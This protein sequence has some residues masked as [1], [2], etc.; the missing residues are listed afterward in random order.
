MLA[1]VMRVIA[2][3]AKSLE[4]AKSRLAPV[5]TP[6]ERA[7]LSVVMLRGVLEACLDQP[8]WEVRVVS[9][10][11]PILD[12][13]ERG[14]A[15]PVLEDGHRLQ[16]AVRQAEAGLPPESEL[17]V[18]LADLP[19][20][21]SRALSAAL[22]LSDHAS[23]VAAPAASDGGTNLLLRHP[24]SAIPARFGRASFVRHRSEAYRRG[25]TFTE[26]RVEELGFD[27]DRPD[28]I[29]TLIERT[30]PNP[31]RLAC[32]EMGLEDRLRVLT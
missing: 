6:A 14:G 1:G 10:D 2:I 31:T 26:A 5:L 19:L 17:V 25:L 18:V 24:P 23:V 9:S 22:R 7:Q 27:L 21:S 3:P 28:D 16:S 4:R 30:D 32:L 20:I 11:P 12:L 15:R 13:A 29:A 8:G